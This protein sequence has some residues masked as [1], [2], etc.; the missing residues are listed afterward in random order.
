M[1]RGRM[2][3]FSGRPGAGKTTI[4]RDLAA[5]LGAVYLRID[6]IEDGLRSSALNLT[7]L[8][9][10][11]YAVGRELASDALAMG[12]IVV[13]DA[14]NPDAECRQGW[15]AVASDANVSIGWVFLTCSDEAEHHRRIDLRRQ[16]GQRRGA[17]WEEVRSRL[18]EPPRENWL[19]VDTAEVLAA[20]AVD[21]VARTY[22]NSGI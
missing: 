4:A 21:L 14:V 19:T 15:D 10:G 11:G 20:D 7:D 9:D 5:R 22:R 1:K 6:S 16:N 13:V 2:I 8:M 3:A 12:Q 17:N 18:I